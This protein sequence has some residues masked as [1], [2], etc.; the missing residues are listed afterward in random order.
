VSILSTFYEQLFRR[1]QKREKDCQIVSLFVLSGSARTKAA[2]RT[3]MKLTSDLYQ[4]MGR[5]IIFITVTKRRVPKLPN[6]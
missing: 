4:E 1:S 3:L 5:P 6:H 2:G